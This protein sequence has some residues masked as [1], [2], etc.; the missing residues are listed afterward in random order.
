MSNIFDKGLPDVLIVS[1]LTDVRAFS[2]ADVVCFNFVPIITLIYHVCIKRKFEIT[3]YSNKTSMVY[4][5]VNKQSFEKNSNYSI[6]IGM[7]M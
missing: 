2:S 5:Q 4:S 1:R 3:V 7:K 6:T